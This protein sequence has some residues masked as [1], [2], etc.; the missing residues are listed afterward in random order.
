[1]FL[2]WPVATAAVVILKVNNGIIMALNSLTTTRKIPGMK[3]R[4]NKKKIYGLRDENKDRGFE[5]FLFI[6]VVYSEEKD[7]NYK[8][9][10]ENG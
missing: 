3:Y 6:I 10:R 5:N 9:D 7:T 8:S 4:R 1:M 2:L